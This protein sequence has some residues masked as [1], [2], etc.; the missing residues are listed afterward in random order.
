MKATW[1]RAV[2]RLVPIF[3]LLLLAP[4]AGAQSNGVYREVWTGLGGSSVPDLTNSA[5]FPNSPNLTN[6]VTDYF[7]A[8][9]DWADY[10]G[11]RLRAFLLPP[12]SG[13]YTFW[14][15][16]DD[17]SLLYLSTDE[18]PA[19]KVAIASVATWTGVRDWS[20]E[21]NQQSAPVFLEGGRRYYLE[22]LQKEGSGGD[23]LAVGWQLPDGSTELPIPAGRGFP[24]TG[25]VSAPPVFAAQPTN[26]ALLEGR[27]AT[28]RVLVSDPAPVRYQWQQNGANIAGATNAAYTLQA[29]ATNLNG[30]QFRCAV[31]NAVGS[32]TSA[33]ATLSVSVDTVPPTLVSALNL[34]LAMVRVVFS[35]PVE[36][37]SATNLANYSI[38]GGVTISNAVLA[39][40]GQSVLLTVSPLTYGLGYTQTVSNVRDLAAAPNTIAPNS[41]FAF[42][43]LIPGIFREVFQGIGGSAVPDLTNNVNFPTNPTTANLVTDYFEAPSNFDENYGQRMRGLLIPPLTGNYVFWIASDDQSVLYLSTDETPL[44]S[45]LIAS[46]SSWTGVREWTKEAGQQSAP[47]P[48]TAGRRYYIE[49][50]HKEGASGDNLSVRWQLP[51]GTMEEPIPASRLS[52]VGMTPPRITAQPTNTTVVEGGSSVFTVQVSNHDPIAYQWQKNGTNVAGAT[53]AVFTNQFVAITDD[54]ARFRCVLTNILGATNTLEAVLTVMPDTIPPEIVSVQNAGTTNVQIVFSE[55]V[56]AVSDTNRSNYAFTNGEAVTV[57]AAAFGPDAKTVILTTSPLV[58]GSNYT[59]VVNNV[60]D[61]SSTPNTIAPDTIFTFTAKEYA[62]LDIGDATPPGA[63]ALV[64]GGLEVSGGGKDI[65][66]SQDQFGFSYQKRTGDFDAQVQLLGLSPAD[67]WSKAGLMARETLDANSRFAGVFATPSLVGAFFES[68]ATTGGAAGLAG[69]LPLNYPNLWLRLKRAGNQ[70]TG[71]L[72]YDGQTWA[73]LGSAN[74]AMPGTVFFGMAVT[75]HNPAQTAVA[76]FGNVTNVTDGT[77]GTIAL[78]AEPIGPSS[79]NTGL[80]ISEIMYHPA[81]RADGRSTE[82]IELF[83]TLP[84]PEDIS[85]Y[86]ISGDVDFTFPQGTVFPAGA[87]LVVAHNPADLQSAYE[88]SKFKVQSSKLEGPNPA[89]LGS[90]YGVFGPYTNNLSNKSG[91]VRLRNR[92][93]AIL[94]EVKYDSDPPWPVAADGAGHSLVLARPSYGEGN[95]QA[96]AASDVIGGSP[97]GMNGAGPEPARAVVINEFLAHSMAPDLDFVELYNH[98]TRPVD[99]SGCFL[100]DEPDTNKFRIP[101]G[102]VIP[103]RGF[104]AFDETQL[105][106]GLSAGGEAIYL[107]NSNRTRVLDAVRFE[108]QG[109]NVACGRS[110]DGAAQW[111]PLAAR[112]PGT[113]NSPV[114]IGDIVINEIMYDPISGDDNDQYVELFNRGTNTVD[115]GRWKFTAGINFTFP[116]NTTLAPDGYLVVAKNVARLL[117]NYPNLTPANT[118]G[119]F[120]G[121]LAHSGERLALAMPEVVVSTN[122]HNLVET[123]THYLVVDEVTYRP[124]GRWGQWAAGGGSSLELIDPRGNHRLAPNWADSD[125]TAKAGWTSVEYTGVL[126]NGMDGWPA[127]SLQLMMAEMGECLVDNV[128]VYASGNPA[129][130][131]VNST[132][133]SG[134]TGWFVQGTHWASSWET[135]GGYAGSRSLHVRASDR[136]DTGANR[137]RTALTTTIASG[138]TATIRAKVKWL[139]GN[140]ELLFRFRGG[141]LETLGKM[142]VPANLG[143]PG[144]PNSR[145]VVNAGPAITE[146]THN[147]PLPAAGQPAVVTARVHDPDGIGSLALKYRVDPATTFT[148]VTMN[149]SG[150]NGDAIA[151]DGV[152]SGT[153]PG[154][155]ANT[156]VAFHLQATDQFTPAATSRFPSDAPVRECFI[157]FGDAMPFSSFGTYRMWMSQALVNRWA[158]MEKL[159][160]ELL[161]CTF[162]YGNCRVVYNAGAHFSGSPFHAQG[163][164]TPMGNACNYK[165]TVP[166]DDTVLGTADFNKLH[167]PGNIGG[168]DTMQREETSCWIAAQLGLPFNYTRFVNLYVNGAQRN[169]IM[170]DMQT[171]GADQLRQWYPGDAD[172]DLFKVSVWAEYADDAAGFGAYGA[173]LGNFTTSGGA[174]KLGRYRWAFGRRALNDSWNDYTNL[175]NLVDAVN[176]ATTNYTA[177]VEAL[178]DVDEWMRVAAVEHIIG[179]WDSWMNTGGQNNY[180]YKPESGKWQALLWDLNIDLGIGGYSDGPTSDLFKVGDGPL[181]TMYNHPPFRRAYWRALQDAADGPLVAANVGAVMDAVYAAFAASGVAA[182]PPTDVKNWIAQR[183]AYILSQLATVT[184]PFA[185]TNNGGNNFSSTNNIISLSGTAP[186]AVKT[187]TVNGVAYPA[188]WTSVNGWRLQLP[189]NGVTNQLVLQGWDWRGNPVT[190]TLAGITVTYTGPADRPEDSLVINEIMYHPLVANAEYI[191]IFNRSTNVTFD[192]SGYRIN[193]VDFTFSPATV[194]GPRGFLVVAKDRTVFAATY[195]SGI[196]VAGEFNGRLDPDGETISLMRPGVAPAQEVIV[197][198][199]K[200]EN[201]APWPAAADGQGPSLQ[202]IDAGQDNRRP[203]NWMAAGSD[204]RFASYTGV[205]R[206][207]RLYIYLSPAGDVFL[208]DLVLV[209]GSVAGVGTNLLRNGDFEAP[210]SGAWTFSSS[211]TSNSALSTTV[212]HAGGNSLHLVFSVGGGGNNTMYQDVTGIVSNNTYTLSFWYLPGSAGNNL[213]SRFS[214]YFMPAFSVRPAVGFTPGTSNSIAAS[215]PA[216][217]PVWINEVQPLNVSGIQ[218]RFGERA[219][220]IELFNAGPASLALDGWYLTDNFA[221]PTNWA[222]PADA[223]IQPGQ[224]L[225]VWADGRPDHNASNELHASFGLNSAT[226]SVALVRSLAGQTL[227]LDYLNYSG[228]DPD[229]SFGSWPDGQPIK[230][231]VFHYVTPG[232]SNNPAALPITVAINEWMAANTGFLLD[233]A[234]GRTDDWFELYNFGTNT[235][236]LAGYY[237]TDTLTNKFQFEIPGGYTIPPGGYL[238]VWADGDSGQNSPGRAD[239]HADF[240]LSRNGEAIGLFAPPPGGALIDA[241]TFGPQADNVSQG[242][243]PDGAGSI[244][245]MPTPTPLAAN[246]VLLPNSPPALGAVDDRV[247]TEGQWLL[248]TASAT[249]TDLPPQTLTYTLDPGAP[250]GAGINPQSGL[251]AWRPAPAQAP[252]TNTLTVRVTD[253]GAPPL[254]DSRTFTV[255]V[256]RLPRISSATLAGQTLDVR[257]PAFPGKTYQVQY[258]EDLVTGLWQNCG[259]PLTATGD[260]L[261]FTQDIRERPQRFYR[262][263]QLN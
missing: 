206:S 74:I 177:A 122:S 114:L 67:V 241:V 1:R 34:G 3:G 129:N 152:F 259:D 221:T 201:R 219:P 132:F 96:W 61:R 99:L 256:L 236:N 13:N 245:S 215:L 260:S 12:A 24:F 39:A 58:F 197:N 211:Y 199:V 191:E 53:N 190:N 186:V 176:N 97:G 21:A 141:W 232:A 164:N 126:D 249:D 124:G 255:I 243:F 56:E 29:V 226:G 51:S 131:A 31:S 36:P 207:S 11:T 229:R 254:S 212:K 18:L 209:A 235:V 223:V 108:A 155:A 83:N 63:S 110:P 227:V 257:W 16:S 109:P 17:N 220:W 55:R 65:G 32:T 135:N 71:Y 48:L 240:Q 44:H 160:N 162:V 79:R 85:G 147:P 203:G 127:D 192:L 41:K 134:V 208:D 230:R 105:G 128:E 121:A 23:S 14:I 69:N 9:H 150:I 224:F 125:E 153:I 248:V 142:S 76:R 216:M 180:L 37:A 75:S 80:V 167:W 115:L 174:K 263:L 258:T 104:V 117:T 38:S 148:T 237:L 233:P 182:N 93:D 54:G 86:R 242:R 185:I 151:G 98:S 116:T 112:T 90:A 92:A 15:S 171:P 161:D 49:A 247:I 102:T 111:Y 244:C 173:S 184:S 210:L 253:D 10:Y 106:F 183:R 217:P 188:T 89:E 113:N 20:K 158:A 64:P 22:A 140:P 77:I 35:E 145:T 60:R 40:D 30:A 33:A 5:A 81:P 169:S 154:Q 68:R 250:E 8:P 43:P 193:G 136:G 45:T 91:T 194:I 26:L 47:I 19:N 2:W 133:E 59:L 231:Q 187:I 82:F 262:V 204:W 6:I 87:F 149:D 225:V 139:K 239:L 214:S 172:G 42:V 178:V 168:D 143:T 234:D 156:V 205:P 50:L 94:L 251:L 7:E 252:G 46:V 196:A 157:L 25:S 246:F 66:G 119:N 138:A 88:S 213:V 163:F 118:L 28:F 57:T 120:G 166:E 238:L 222:F 218:D 70:F 165:L 189:L 195:G 159:S 52:P 144:A 200:Y 103:A 72:S 146:V 123:N 261:S 179:N 175:F 78:A 84:Y 95:S 130:L 27:P 107:V 228:V 101:D 137:I 198:Q 73:Q 202:L 170:E 62:V 100:S 4:A 181:N